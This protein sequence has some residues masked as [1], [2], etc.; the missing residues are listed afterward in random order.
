MCSGDALELG[1]RRDRLAAVLGALVVD[2][3]QQGLVGLDDQGSVVHRLVRTV[4]GVRVFP[5]REVTADSMGACDPHRSRRRRGCPPGDDL[6]GRSARRAA[7]REGRRAGRGQGRVRPPAR[8]RGSAAPSR[9]PRSCRRRWVPQLGDAEEV[10]GRP[11]R[12]RA[13][14]ARRPGARAQRARPRPRAEARGRRRSRSSAAP[15]RPSRRRTSTARVDRAVRDVRARSWS[16]PWPS[17]HVGAGLRVDVLRRPVGGPG[18]GRAGRRRVPS[19]SSTSAATSCRLGDTIGV[20]TTG[21]VHRLL[22]AL[23]APGIGADRRR[24]ALPRHLRPGAGQHDGGAARRRH[25]R[26]RVGRR[27]RRLPLRQVAPP[28]TSPPR[29]SSGRWTAPASRPA[30]TSTRW[31]RRASGWPG[32]SAGPRR[33]NVVRALAGA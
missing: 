18:A 30:S 15:P 33:R 1:E 11:R 16:A 17:G 3:E 25:G 32:S 5:R 26:R 29:T 28:A 14:A 7:E 21:H 23:D 10:L 2:L 24:R 4:R 13:R 12:R 31:S 9:R 8:G 27:P 19:G 6:R 22:E 20:G